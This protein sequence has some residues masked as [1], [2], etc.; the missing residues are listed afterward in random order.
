MPLTIFAR[1]T[2]Q[3][4]FLVDTITD[5]EVMVLKH[6]LSGE[7]GVRRWIS[8]AVRGKINN[9]KKRMV[10]E[11]LFYARKKKISPNSLSDD[12]LI[13]SF[14]R[15]RIYKDKEARQLEQP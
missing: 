4:E 3:T 13:A 14:V 12:D 2:D 5:A 7:E 9:A 8:D 15:A 11:A 6:V 10:E 1:N